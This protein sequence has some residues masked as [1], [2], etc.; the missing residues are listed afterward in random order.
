MQSFCALGNT[1]QCQRAVVV[2][3]S[4]GPPRI[5]RSEVVTGNS[6]A[7]VDGAEGKQTFYGWE[8]PVY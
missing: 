8:S 6:V 4:V 1:C 2:R 7:R 5:G 3:L